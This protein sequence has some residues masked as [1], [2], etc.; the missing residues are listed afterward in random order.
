MHL[1]TLAFA[2]SCIFLAAVVRGYAGFGFSLLSITA[3]SIVMEP[4]QIVPSIFLLE[5]AASAHLLVTAWRD[6]HWSSLGWLAAGCLI[7]TPVGVYLLARLPAAPLTVALAMVVLLVAGLLARGF[8]LASMPGRSATLGTGLI[9][10]LLNGSIGVGGP[11]VVLFFFGSPA[12]VTTGRASMIAY[13][14]FTDILG[15]AWQWHDGLIDRQ[16]L[17]R[18]LFYAP[19]LLGGVWLGNRAF[20]AVDPARFRLWVLRLLVVLALLS[21]GRAL[22]EWLS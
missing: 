22:F 14:L 18:A 2:L 3:L 21:G 20:G 6:V 7:G 19:A 15:L 13:F 11:P 10:G 5:V 17:E 1:P 9:S 16:V 8:V 12:G 4:R